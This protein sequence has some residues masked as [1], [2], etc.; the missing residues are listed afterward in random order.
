MSC[1]KNTFLAG[2]LRNQYLFES[3]KI[4]KNSENLIKSG[5]FGRTLQW[6][7]AVIF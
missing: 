7:A 3:L 2:L 5:C 1:V 4:I 6:R